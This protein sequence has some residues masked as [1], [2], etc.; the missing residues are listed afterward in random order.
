MEYIDSFS[1]F[2]PLVNFIY[3][4]L[5]II[6]SMVFIHFVFLIISISMGIIY[7]FY[8][9]GLENLKSNFKFIIPML[10]VTAI[11]NPL[12]NHEGMTIL[13]YFPT[14]NPLTLESILYGIAAGMMFVSVIIWFSSYNDII[15]SDKFIYLFGKIIP[16]LSL[17]I[18]MVLR[19]VPMF[20]RK[21]KEVEKAQKSLGK[22]YSTGPIRDRIRNGLTIISIMITWMLESS[23]ETADSMRSRGYGL[24]GRTNF[25]IF[26]FEKKDLLASIYLIFGGLYIII[27][28]F[29]KGMYYRYFPNFKVEYNSGYA[30]SIFI[31]Y[32]GLCALPLIINIWED[33][34]W[35]Y[36]QSKI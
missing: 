27:G 29:N 7:S 14:G 30:I 4:T 12:F 19:F 26:T 16:S 17:V 36:S 32:L 22:D 10:L 8:L 21:L 20:R 24:K 33:L 35:K 1:S 6:F 34:K 9:K 13:W 23:I 28:Y 18:S 31:I 25:S 15:S 11:I 3:F 5:V 2:H